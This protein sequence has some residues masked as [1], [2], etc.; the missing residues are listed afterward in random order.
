MYNFKRTDAQAQENEARR[1]S[2]QREGV[3]F[4]GRKI[5]NL[6]SARRANKCLFASLCPFLSNP[7]VLCF[8]AVLIAPVW[9]CSVRVGVLVGVRVKGA[10]SV[11]GFSWV[12]IYIF[13]N[14]K[15]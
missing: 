7:F 10:G 1:M 14:N 8:R 15:F 4:C 2:T 13:L 6:T 9:I 12:H 5:K 3:Q 11:F